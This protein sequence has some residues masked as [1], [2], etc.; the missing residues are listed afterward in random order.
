ME[1]FF[2]RPWII[3]ALIALVTAFFLIQLPKAELDNN[4][5]RFVPDNDPARQL[6]ERIDE[7]FGSQ[8]FIMVGFERRY[9]S[10]LDADFLHALREYE[11]RVAALP[12]VE[13]ISS[14]SNTDYIGGDGDTLYVEPLVPESFSGTKE[15]LALIRDRLMEWDMYDRSLISDDFSATQVLVSLDVDTDTA[16]SPEAVQAYK[17]IKSIAYEVN[18]PATEIYVTGIP[19]FSAVINDATAADL[20]ILI[21]LVA[22]VVLFI[23]SVSFRRLSG[24]LLPLLTVA[25]SAVWAIGAMALL[26]VRLSIISTVLPV[27]LVAVGS[28]YGIHVV[29]HYYDALAASV[30]LDAET[31][32]QLVFRILRKVSRPV[33]LAALTTLAGFSSLSFTS[34]VPIAEF[35]IFASFGVACA[36][37]VSLSL[38]PALFLI[39]GP[40][41]ASRALSQKNGSDVLSTLIADLF[42]SITNKRRTVL[43]FGL[44]V[45]GLSLVG[46]RYLI[47]DNVMVEYFRSDTDI[48]RSD[49]F[50]REQFGGSKTLS[51]VVSHKDRSAVL[52]PELLSAMDDLSRFIA[53]DVP[54]V[55]KTLAFTDLVKRMNQVLHADAPPEGLPASAEEAGNSTGAFGDGG[56]GFGDESS[57]GFGDEASFG[58]S[59][60]S[61]EAVPVQEDEETVLLADKSL[62]EHDLN[63]LLNQALLDS[64]G[65]MSAEELVRSLG[66]KTNYRGA[67]YYEVPSDPERYG[68]K[69]SSGLKALV[70]NY[71]VLLGSDISALSDDPLEPYTIR[72]SLQLR[73]VGQKDTLRAIHAIQEFIRDRFPKGYTVEI[74]GVAL[75]EESLNR[76]V[77]ESQLTSVIASLALVFLILAIYYR[78]AMAGFFGLIPLGTSILINFGVMGAFGI[79]LNIGTAMVASIAVGVG[80]DYIIHY[81]AAYHHAYL[82]G[83]RGM[84]LLRSTYLSSGKAI[85]Y[86]AAS[87]GAGFAVLA[88]SQFSILAYLGILICLTMLTSALSSLTVLPV[89]LNTF[90]PSFIRRPLPFE[91]KQKDTEVQS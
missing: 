48:V 13:E 85:V 24:V 73:T 52:E 56:F 14:I 31:H 57:F 9:G 38:I 2:K 20:R 90:N 72:M 62:T 15:E 89:L 46:I 27:I 64:K 18:F 4:N 75:V 10:V 43:F 17:K 35:G 74:G 41:K 45:L 65:N 87:V 44:L 12:V 21:P 50:I 71:L 82:E 28:A 22:I 40:P 67:A 42:C 76:L 55:G 66:R 32:K 69:D 84:D 6:T 25:I 33:F 91:K 51:L 37:I 26:D 58:F 86:N 78:S 1:R 49:V 23:L 53:E 34:V 5:F 19:V 79:K 83:K 39:I 29:N 60:V 8:I 81:L 3:V 16:G 11:T 68:K 59:G 54:E 80:I 30:E 70:S 77:V 47:I 36:F 63:V 61:Q 88:L 7:K